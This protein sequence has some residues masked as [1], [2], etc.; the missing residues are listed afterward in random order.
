M[1]TAVPTRKRVPPLHAGDHLSVDEFERR[2]QAMPHVNKAELIEG[3]VY[4]PSCDSADHAAARFDVLGWL[5]YYRAFTP[6]VRGAAH[7]MLRFEF[8]LHRPQPAA[9]LRILPNHGGQS[10]VKDR[11]IIGAPELTAEVSAS[12]ASYDLH[13]KL[14]AYRRNGVREYVVWR[15]EDEAID[16]FVLRHEKYEPL[17]LSAQGYYQSEVFPGLWLDPDALIKADAPRLLAVLQQGLASPEHADF[18]ARMKAAAVG[19]V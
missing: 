3:V 1:T 15:V 4:L 5:G 13:E 19:H 16:W 7:S 2:Y 6:G 9:L 14:E 8:G 11:Y 17:P 12:S 10:Q 18:V